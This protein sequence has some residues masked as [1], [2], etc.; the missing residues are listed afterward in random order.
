VLFRRSLLDRPL[1][2]TLVATVGL[3]ALAVLATS[4]EVGGGAE[5]GGRYFAVG[6]PVV[7]ALVVLSIGSTLSWSDPLARRCLLGLGAVSL[8]LAVLAVHQLAWSHHLNDARTEAIVAMVD[9]AGPGSGPDLGDGDRR[10]IVAETNVDAGRF[11]WDQFE[12]TRGIQV[13]DE[14]ISP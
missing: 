8:R 12:R 1:A 13:A 2:V 3:F 7:A 11:A 9:A 14:N 5:W 10:P 6:F 4:Y